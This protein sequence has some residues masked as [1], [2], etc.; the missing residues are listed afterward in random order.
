MTRMSLS[1]RS[2]LLTAPAFAAA[3]PNKTTKKPLGFQLYSV[4][5]FLP[6]RAS[7]ALERLA[8]AGYRQVETL[9]AT[10]K[11]TLPLCKQFGLTPIA[12]HY[13]TG[14]FNGNAKVWNLPAGLTFDN[15]LEEAVA[16]GQKYMVIPYLRPDER[17]GLDVF[18]R[19]A[20][21]VNKAGEKASKAGIQICY[22]NHAFEFATVDG[23][24]PIDVLLAATDPKTLALELDIFWVAVT[25]EDPIAAIKKWK[26]RIKLFHLKDK[27]PGVPKQFTEAV[28]PAAFREVGY[29]VLDFKAIL[30]ACA[31][32]GVEQYFVEQDQVAGDAVESLKASHDYLVKLGF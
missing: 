24:R 2:A 22:H 1:R 9:R 7:L 15:A 32:A 10:H 13:E 4:R 28:A 27:A 12:G 18:K 8:Q 11:I 21:Q 3:A 31:E 14:F 16:A 6:D 29:G 20:D 5:S 30:K 25:G 19:L 26:G 23:Q 17:G